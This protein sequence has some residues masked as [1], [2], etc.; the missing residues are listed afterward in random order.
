MI[1]IHYFYC[2]H[3]SRYFGVTANKIANHATCQWYTYSNCCW[4]LSFY[5]IDLPPTHKPPPPYTER[6][7]V[8]PLASQAPQV[9]SFSQVNL[10]LLCLHCG[11]PGPIFWFIFLLW[12]FIE[13]HSK[14]D[15]WHVSYYLKSDYILSF[16]SLFPDFSLF[17]FPGIFTH[18]THNTAE[19]YTS[20]RWFLGLSWFK[21]VSH[22]NK[23][24]L[25]SGQQLVFQSADEKCPSKKP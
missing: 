10:T 25:L 11:G 3:V 20:L 1:F 16:S 21:L 13:L 18:P 23:V 14:D 2:G 5:R 6:P 12:Y 19:K 9:A 24:G 22:P 7:P 17:V 15:Y 8:I 4:F